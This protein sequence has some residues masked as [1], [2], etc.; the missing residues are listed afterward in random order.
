MM[1]G[2]ELQ[3][4]ENRLQSFDYSSKIFDKSGNEYG[5]FGLTWQGVAHRY[6]AGSGEL[7]TTPENYCNFLNL[8]RDTA[9]SNS[10]LSPTIKNQLFKPY[11]TS[12][13]SWYAAGSNQYRT[14]SSKRIFDHGGLLWATGTSYYYFNE[15]SDFHFFIACND[16]IPGQ[17]VGSASEPITQLVRSHFEN[18]EN[19]YGCCSS[20]NQRISLK[21]A[22]QEVEDNFWNE[23]AKIEKIN[24]DVIDIESDTEDSPEARKSCE[25]DHEKE[26]YERICSCDHS[27]HVDPEGKQQHT[28]GHDLLL[29]EAIEENP[30]LIEELA[31]RD[32]EAKQRISRR[33][34]ER[35][36]LARKFQ[37][38]GRSLEEYRNAAGCVYEI[39]VYFHIIY[40]NSNENFSIAALQSQIDQLN[41]DFSKNRDSFVV[42]DPSRW[43]QCWAD[44]CI[45]FTWNPNDVN[46]VN[47]NY[48]TEAAHHVLK[49]SENGGSDYV[50]NYMN[51]WVFDTGFAGL[52]T[53]PSPGFIT[54][55]LDGV[56]IAPY[57]V[58]NT[59]VSDMNTYYGYGKLSLMK[60]GII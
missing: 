34:T 14:N 20:N 53:I 38:E 2:L 7:I 57:T 5:P 49:K 25:L 46:R 44:T 6:W 9:L 29:K 56:V 3:I 42:K 30:N 18:W 4:Y 17:T 32:V 24:Y 52:G 45:R 1:F 59:P 21:L 27:E 16:A 11:R 37:Q 13:S 10:I 23:Q 28:C 33:K 8:F 55:D 15:I 48:G 47:T 50:P 54:N 41:R 36:A 58:P 22:P 43:D 35:Q 31:L 40:R 19:K 12:W 39:K 51:V 60:R 26:K